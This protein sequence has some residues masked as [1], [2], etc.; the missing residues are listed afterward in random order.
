MRNTRTKMGNVYLFWE[1]S[2]VN[3]KLFKNTNVKVTFKETNTIGNILNIVFK[4][5]GCEHTC[6]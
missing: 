2:R 1:L 3:L 6:M 4:T 5:N